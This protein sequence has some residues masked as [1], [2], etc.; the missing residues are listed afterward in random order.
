MKLL[1]IVD[2]RSP[3]ALNWIHYFT[4]TTQHQVMV[5][6]T[7]PCDPQVLPGIQIDQIPV[8]FTGRMQGGK[9]EPSSTSGS[10]VSHWQQYL[11]RTSSFEL[12]RLARLWLTTFEVQRHVQ[13]IRQRI[14]QYKPDLVHAMRIPFE[15][16]VAAKATPAGTPLLVSVWGNDFTLHAQQSRLIARQTRQTLARTN[17]LHADCQRDI[18]LGQKWGLERH[19]PTIVLPGAGGIQGELFRPAPPNDTL[20]QNLGIPA[21]ATIIINPRGI[22]DYVRNDLFF[23]AIPKVLARKPN[24][25]FLCSNM[26]GNTIAENWVR[27]LNLATSVRLLPQVSRQ[28]MADYFRLAQIAVSPSLHDGTPNTLLESMACGCFPVAGDIESIR[29]WLEPGLNALLFDPNN[30]EAQAR[31]LLQAIDN[32]PLRHRS[33]HHNQKLVAERAEYQT[34]MHKAES[35]YCGLV[36]KYAPNP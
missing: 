19:K 22:R 2:G 14:V 16:I 36:N 24:T 23:Q 30:V 12:L 11:R 7:Y 21:G 3:I 18:C 1:F 4:Q 31:A 35:F 8:G 25:F 13:S 6:S 29:E 33:Q 34:V 32:Q 28:Q 27:Q 10:F 20:R 15:G 9:N 26:A 17:A 5:I